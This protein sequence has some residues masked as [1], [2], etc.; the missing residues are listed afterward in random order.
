MYDFTYYVASKKISEQT[1]KETN[2]QTQRTNW[3]LPDA[4]SVGKSEK[5][6]RD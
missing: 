4:V 5:S 1:K 2:T 3:Q 6:E